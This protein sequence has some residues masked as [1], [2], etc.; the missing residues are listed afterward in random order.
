MVNYLKSRDN[1]AFARRKFA[2]LC[3]RGSDAIYSP[4]KFQLEDARAS[5]RERYGDYFG[6]RIVRPGNTAR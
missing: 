1:P 6:G 4:N 5:A 2:R 3:P